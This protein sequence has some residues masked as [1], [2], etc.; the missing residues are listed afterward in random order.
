MEDSYLDTLY[1][2][3][4]DPCNLPGGDLQAWEDEQVFQDTIAEQTDE[5]V[6]HE[7]GEHE[8]EA[9]YFAEQAE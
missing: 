1:E 2:D 3:M 8:D 9:D 4:T 7:F 5:V 6:Y